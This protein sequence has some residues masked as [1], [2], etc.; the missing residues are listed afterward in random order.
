MS[1]KAHLENQLQQKA[2]DHF[3]SYQQVT[4]LLEEKK[5]LLAI[6]RQLCVEA[7]KEIEVG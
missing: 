4:D 3:K 1:R 6:I 5:V 7:E 2:D